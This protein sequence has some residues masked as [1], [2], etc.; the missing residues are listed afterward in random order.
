MTV[1]IDTLQ[2]VEAV[3]AERIAA[4]TAPGASWAVFDRGGVA[5]SG[6]TGVVSLDPGSPGP[7]RVPT[8]CSA[9]RAARRASPPR[10]CSCCA[11]ADCSTSMPRRDRSS[12]SSSPRFRVASTSIRPCGCS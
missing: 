5:A 1:A 3:F 8:R 11:I 4:G 10:P 6:G 9:S 7:H 12:P 2:A